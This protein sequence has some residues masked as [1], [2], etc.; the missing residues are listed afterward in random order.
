MDCIATDTFLCFVAELSPELALLS[1]I[2]FDGFLLSHLQGQVHTPQSAL[3]AVESFPPLIR[4]C[5]SVESSRKFVNLKFSINFKIYL[6][7]SFTAFLAPLVTSFTVA[8]GLSF[9]HEQLQ[10]E[11]E[12]EALEPIPPF[13]CNCSS[14]ESSR[15]FDNFNFLIIDNIYLLPTLYGFRLPLFIIY[16]LIIFTNHH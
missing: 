14:V 15:K 12:H 10:P 8:F 11:H 13:R 3:H 7:A 9:V 16:Y 5:S 2:D 4:N 6:L 1:P